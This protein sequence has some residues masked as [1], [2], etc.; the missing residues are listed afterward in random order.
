MYQYNI[1]FMYLFFALQYSGKLSARH[2]DVK[3]VSMVSLLVMG[4]EVLLKSL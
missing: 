1:C 2:G 4:N 3:T